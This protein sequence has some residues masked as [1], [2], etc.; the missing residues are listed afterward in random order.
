LGAEHVVLTLIVV[1]GA[2]FGLIAL[3]DGVVE[4][5]TRAFD[6]AIL[7]VFRNSANLAEPIGPPWLPDMV[8]DLTSLGSTAV[9]TLITVGAIGY[10]MIDRKPG[11]ALF[12]LVAIGGGTMVSSMLRIGVQRL[13]PDLVPALVHETSP[14]FPSGHAM[15]STVT[16]LT[17]GVILARVQP[18][19]RMKIYILTAAA[20]VALIVGVS[21]VYLGVHWPTDVLAGWCAGAAWA[22]FCWLIALWLQRR[23]QIE[24]ES[25]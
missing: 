8:R 13:R 20:V 25:T 12:V 22:L 21:R 11:A 7:K 15:L 23:G 18:G 5:S 4:G 17:I 19:R 14:S 6:T 2:L 1:V 9:L 3:M 24:A 16:Y 10:L